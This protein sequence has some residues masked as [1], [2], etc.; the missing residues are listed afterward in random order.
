MAAIASSEEELKAPTDLE[1]GHHN[2]ISSAAH[3]ILPLEIENGK[4]G[5]DKAEGGKV[6][7]E[8]HEAAVAK[9]GVCARYVRDVSNNGWG[10]CMSVAFL[11][12][13][14][15]HSHTPVPLLS[16][17]FRHKGKFLC[18]GITL[19]ILAAIAIA[20]PLLW[21]TEPTAELLSQSALRI[22]GLGSMQAE[23]QLEVKNTN[24]YPGT[25]ACAWRSRAVGC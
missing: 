23:L 21:Y 20:V 3:H 14:F 16:P 18:L 19:A 12:L 25:R 17:P 5:L 9:Q 13:R 22:N 7:E 6:L 24:R 10:G 4:G 2:E 11:T 15:S 1:Y 8:E